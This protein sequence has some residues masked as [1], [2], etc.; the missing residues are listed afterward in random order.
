MSAL[1][2]QLPARQIKIDDHFRFPGD[3]MIFRVTG[4]RGDTVYLIDRDGKKSSA[5]A[6]DIGNCWIEA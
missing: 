6:V 3:D 5:F 1:S 4:V 2:P